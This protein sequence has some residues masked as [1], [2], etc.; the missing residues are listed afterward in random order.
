[1]IYYIYKITNINT[2][3]VYVGSHQTNNIEDGYFG[4]GI[5]LKRAIAKYGMDQFKKEIIEFCTSKDEMHKRETEIL[6]ELQNQNTYN[7]K[8]CALGGNTR[9][10]YSSAEK[11]AYVQKLVNNP[12]SPIGKKGEQAFNYGKKAS[13]AVCKKMRESRKKYFE[14]A[15]PDKIQQWKNN[16][17]KSAKSRCA[18]MT[19]I[20]SKPVRVECKMT[21]NIIMFKSKTECVKFFDIHID[22]LDRYTNNTFT[23]H[24]KSIKKLLPYYIEYIIK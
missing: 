20:N 8:Y 2:Q 12:N 3:K 13:D 9:I 4:S 18:L 11:K 15:P 24:T 23:I 14:T 1:M 16:V 10:K 21:G 19:E 7:L 17:I 5:Y 22:T 6:L